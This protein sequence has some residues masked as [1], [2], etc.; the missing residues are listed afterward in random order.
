[1]LYHLNVQPF[2]PIDF[3]IICKA[4]SYSDLSRIHIDL[5]KELVQFY[6]FANNNKLTLYGTEFTVHDPIHKVNGRCN[7]LFRMSEGD[8]RNLMIYDWTRSPLMD[9][10]SLSVL[11]KTLQLN[12][13]KHILEKF[14][15]KKI[16]K[17]HTIVFHKDIKE[18]K[19]LEIE[20]IGFSSYIDDENYMKM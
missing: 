6:N 7:A 20:D 12:I 4:D 14:Y 5:Y 17:M 1:M 10:G 11:R 9:E 8:D 19:D 18:Y 15:H 2:R 13:Y 3:D 16:I